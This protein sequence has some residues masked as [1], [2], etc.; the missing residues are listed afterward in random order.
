ML[1]GTAAS[2]IAAEVP[3][4]DTSHQKGGGEG[5]KGG[6]GVGHADQGR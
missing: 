6:I 3:G 4:L 1:A 2:T 5:G